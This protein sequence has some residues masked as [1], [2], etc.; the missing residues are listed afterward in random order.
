MKFINPVFVIY[1]GQNKNLFL[2]LFEVKL[3]YCAVVAED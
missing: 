3:I 1:G 2:L